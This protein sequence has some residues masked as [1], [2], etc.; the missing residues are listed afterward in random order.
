M[1]E[2]SRQIIFQSEDQEYCFKVKRRHASELKANDYKM[3]N[4][5]YPEIEKLRGKS[6]ALTPMERKEL[7]LLLRKEYL[8]KHYIK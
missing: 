1:L 5:I 3:L 7:I 2:T 6:E 8:I 4:T